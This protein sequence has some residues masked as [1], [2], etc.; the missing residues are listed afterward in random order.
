VAEGQYTIRYRSS[1]AEAGTA[2]IVEDEGGRSY[3][4]TRQGLGCA[5]RS[6]PTPHPIARLLR[7]QNWVPVA[8]VTPHTLDALCHLAQLAR[9]APEEDEALAS[10]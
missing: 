7:E 6:T 1:D 8:E 5:W 4:L 9:L 2:L 10:K 3:L